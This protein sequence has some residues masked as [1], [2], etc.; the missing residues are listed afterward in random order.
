M[1]KG[2]RCLNENK[3]VIDVEIVNYFSFIK[4][5]ILTICNM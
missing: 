5:E 4:R 1:I 3:N 2:R